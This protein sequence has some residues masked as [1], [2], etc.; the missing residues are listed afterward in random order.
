MSN[1]ATKELKERL[2][3]LPPTVVTEL[4]SGLKVATEDSGAPTATVGLW[5]DAGSRWETE[6]T[7]G[8]AHFLEHMAFKVYY[9][10]WCQ[11]GSTTVLCGG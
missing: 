9:G 1:L 6:E 5:I 2:M 11:F 3:N 10:T 4:G 8:V 7:N